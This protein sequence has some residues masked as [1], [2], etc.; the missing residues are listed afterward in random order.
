MDKYK[1][2]NLSFEE[3][4]KDLVSKLTLDEK[5]SQLTHESQAI[6]RLNIPKYN[7]WNEALHG[8]ARSGVATVFPQAIGLA[9][10]W[11][12]NLMSEVA[13]TISDEARAKHHEYLRQGHID[14]YTG[15]NFWSPN[16]NIF[17]DLRWGRGHETYGEDPKL[18]KEMGIRF[19]KGLQGNGKY[20]KA[21]ACAKHFAVHSGPEAGRENFNSEVSNKDLYETYLPA[22]EALVKEAKVESV[23]SAYNSVWHKP[24]S[25]NEILLEDILRKKWGFKGHVVSDCGA[26]EH[27][28]QFFKITSCTA[29]S[30]A[31]ALKAGC[32]LNCGYAYANMYK[33]M[34]ENLI[35][36]EAIDKSCTRLLTTRFKL[37]MFDDDVE[38]A[39]IPYEVVDCDKNRDLAL[40][41][42]KEAVILL[43]NNGILPLN[44]LKTIAV[45]GPN[46]DE[47]EVHLGN[48]NG[49]PSKCPS[50][51]ES[52]RDFAEPKGIKVLYAKGCTMANELF[53]PCASDLT[54]GFSEAKSIAQRSDI[55]IYVGGLNSRIEGEAGDAF[56]SDAGGDRTHLNLPGVQDDLIK[57]L[58]T[59]GKPV[60]VIN[61][62]GGGVALNYAQENA[63]AILQCM[64]LG[65]E[66]GN[67]IA[68]VLFG[69]HNPSGRTPYTVPK[70]IDDLPDFHNYSME[71]RTYKYTTKEPLYT[72]GFGLSYTKFSYSNLKAIDK[73]TLSIDVK[74]TGDYAGNE[75]VQAYISLLDAPCRVPISELIAFDKVLLEKGETKTVILNLDKNTYTYVDM[76][77]NR[78]N[79]NDKYKISVGGSLGDKRSIELGAPA[80]LNI[81]L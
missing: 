5:I 10:T 43:K 23:M 19:V 66:A 51:L 48:Y 15:I 22:F 63:D 45:I 56:N 37:G 8:V 3:R 50:V 46:A 52:I 41:A 54:F 29:E 35:A 70:S 60:I 31:M 59:L 11:D 75:I 24:C 13:N 72:F 53:T 68:S 77:G 36:E 49:T 42:A 81:N 73:Y 64:Y 30:A 1:D 40:K 80:N 58:C 62:S 44:N 38:Y 21:A 67:A 2:K 74:N 4:A 20:L 33:A 79:Y 25:G 9:S 32:D 76:E 39:S 27:I 61:I 65:E 26:V 34:K 78:I 17:R 55:I 6:E 69:E 14:M 18:T 28:H 57:E 12:L 16:I 7:W 71:N 47:K